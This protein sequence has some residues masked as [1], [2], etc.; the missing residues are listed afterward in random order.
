MS[1]LAGRFVFLGSGPLRAEVR[2]FLDQA[3]RPYI[4]KPAKR[5]ALL[6]AIESLLAAPES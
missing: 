5:E 2:A 6:Q 3:G 4:E 1:S